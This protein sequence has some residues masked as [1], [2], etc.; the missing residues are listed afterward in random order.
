MMRPTIEDEIQKST[1]GYEMRL[2]HHFN[3]I[4]IQ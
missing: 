2:D 3:P 4:A 1:S